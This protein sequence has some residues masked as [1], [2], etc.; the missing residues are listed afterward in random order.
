MG[1]SNSGRPRSRAHLGMFLR[2]GASDVAQLGNGDW[3]SLRWNAGG[4]I[5][6]YGAQHGVELRFNCNG[7][8]VRQPV[9]VDRLPCHFG[10]TRP[11]LRCPHCDQRCRYLYLYGTRFVCR[12][13]TRAPYW[14]QTASPD[15][16]MARRI[17]RTQHRLAPGEDADDYTIE[18][19]PDRPK[20]MRQR[21]Y[22]KLVERLEWLN[23]KRDA[24][25]EPGLLRVLARCI[26]QDQMD[27]LLKDLT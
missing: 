13:C 4:N 17:R 14:T 27:D 1:N 5:G 19:I 7:N 16:R 25:L 24:Y 9:T 10:G 22:G 8:E 2:L 23:D 11:M 3:R 15:A 12:T 20:G 6:V 21:T 18:W 26:T